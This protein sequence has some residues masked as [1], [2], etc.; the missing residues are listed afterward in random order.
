MIA[1]VK[2]RGSVFFIPSILQI[3]GLANASKPTVAATGL[4]ERIIN[5]FPSNT[6]SAVGIAGLK[7]M[8]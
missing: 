3:K 4:P 2:G 5:G 7:A 1:L 6:A 8:P